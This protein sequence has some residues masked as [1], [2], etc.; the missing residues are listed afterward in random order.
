MSTR[1]VPA[2][3]LRS[4]QNLGDQLRT[5]RKLQSLT[6]EQ[7]AARAGVNRETVSRLEHGDVAVGMGTLLNVARA[8]GILDNLVT[9][10]DPF[11]TDFGRARADQT[12]PKR[13]RS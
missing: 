7:L 12:L 2:R 5:W 4:A 8:L 9:A 1:P 6:I 10:L 11:E 3:T 13:V